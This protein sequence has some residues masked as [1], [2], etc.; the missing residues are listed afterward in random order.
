[1]QNSTLS[2]DLQTVSNQLNNW[3][4]T[5]QSSSETMPDS[6]K[7]LIAKLVPLYS[8]H[9]I[10]K[11][12]RIKQSTINY[13]Y[14]NYAPAKPSVGNAKLCNDTQNIDFIPIQLSS[15]FATQNKHS[16]TSYNTKSQPPSASTECHF[17][18]NNGTKLIIHVQD[19]N[20]VIKTFLC[21]N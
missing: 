17:I 21:S 16:D 15:L 13:F 19:V 7:N 1:M 2:L 10:S 14:K 9:D 5:R 11:A 12:L 6:L 3:R 18:K 4:R 20:D 8:I